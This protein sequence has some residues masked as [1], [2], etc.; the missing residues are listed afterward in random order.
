VLAAVLFG[1]AHLSSQGILGAS[2]ATLLGLGLGLIMIFHRSVW[3]AV[4]AHGVF[5]AT[6]MALLPWVWQKL[7]PFQQGLGLS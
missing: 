5:D 2:N 6:S 4:I 1:I 7:H 3:P